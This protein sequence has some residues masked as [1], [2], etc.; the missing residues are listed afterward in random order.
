MHF[1]RKLQTTLHFTL[2]VVMHIK[3]ELQ[4]T[5]VAVVVFFKEMYSE[6]KYEMTHL[7]SYTVHTLYN[8]FMC[9]RI[10]LDSQ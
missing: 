7:W 10:Q 3:H 1:T 9:A 4:I 8:V 5:L 2:C 6:K